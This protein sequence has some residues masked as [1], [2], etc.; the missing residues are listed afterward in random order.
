[1]REP[2]ATVFVGF[3]A[4]RSPFAS[5]LDTKSVVIFLRD[6]EEEANTVT[7]K[8]SLSLFGTFSCFTPLKLREIPRVHLVQ[9]SEKRTVE[10]PSPALNHSLPVT[11]PTLLRCS[12]KL[13]DVFIF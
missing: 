12:S 10:T 7:E 6:K 3:H 13:S 5:P 9:L 11:R 4:L 2:L 1:M 8:H